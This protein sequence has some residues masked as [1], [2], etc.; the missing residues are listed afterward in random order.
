MFFSGDIGG[1]IL[2]DLNPATTYDLRF[3]AKNRVGFS[4][5]GANQQITTP[6]RGR[7]EPP[8]I[9]KQTGAG[10][11]ID[12][13]IVELTD[14]DHYE[15]SWQIPEDNGVPIDYFLLTYHPV[16]RAY[17]SIFVAVRLVEKITVY[18]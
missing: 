18:L 12:G 8:I 17:C 15:V 3:G 16:S 5:W 7:P 4:Q 6:K 13:D 9:H 14:P 11:I 10:E 1:Y 2:E